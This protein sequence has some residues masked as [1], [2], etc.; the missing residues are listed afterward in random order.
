MMLNGVCVTRIV[1]KRIG[2]LKSTNPDILKAMGTGFPVSGWM[3][4]L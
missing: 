1:P 2:V 3:V 4:E